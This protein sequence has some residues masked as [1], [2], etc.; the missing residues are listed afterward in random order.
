MF[1]VVSQFPFDFDF[2]RVNDPICSGYLSFSPILIDVRILI[3]CWK[4]EFY[5]WEFLRFPGFDW[6]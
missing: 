3:S 4:W 5:A 2:W 6:R 1:F